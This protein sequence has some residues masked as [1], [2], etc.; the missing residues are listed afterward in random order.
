MADLSRL[1]PCWGAS[2]VGTKLGRSESIVEACARSGSCFA[3][4]V[5]IYKKPLQHGLPNQNIRSIISLTGF[6]RKD[7]I[8]DSK[9]MTRGFQSRLSKPRKSHHG[10]QKALKVDQSPQH[11]TQPHS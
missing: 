4:G 7:R 6:N 8:L 11:Q 5:G 2:R 9:S 10:V 3:L 1:E